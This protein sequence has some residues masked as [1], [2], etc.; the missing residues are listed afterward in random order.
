MKFEDLAVM[1]DPGLKLLKCCSQAVA[2]AWSGKYDVAGA[3]SVRLR[4]RDGG[5]RR[6]GGGRILRQGYVSLTEAFHGHWIDVIDDN[7]PS[8]SFLSSNFS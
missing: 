5:E 6:G 4:A 1:L 2:L 7:V 3:A 8:H